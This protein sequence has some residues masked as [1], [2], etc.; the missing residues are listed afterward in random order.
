M[1]IYKIYNLKLIEVEVVKE[2]KFF[3]YLDDRPLA[4]GCV[5]R[6]EKGWACLSPQ[7]AIQEALNGRKTMQGAFRDKL[8]KIEKEIEALEALE[9]Q[10]NPGWTNLC[11]I[12]GQGPEVD[13]GGC[14]NIGMHR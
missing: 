7:E 4:F 3:Y 6:I 14:M 8:I 9:R 10:Y 13:H 5:S 11:K 1:K 2:T 12:C